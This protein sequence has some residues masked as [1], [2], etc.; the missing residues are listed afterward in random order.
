LGHIRGN[1]NLLKPDQRV[2]AYVGARSEGVK[3][4]TGNNIEKIDLLWADQREFLIPEARSEDIKLHK[5][6]IREDIGLFGIRSGRVY[7]S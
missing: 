6:K 1:I 5:G 7:T 2:Y 3:S 4:V